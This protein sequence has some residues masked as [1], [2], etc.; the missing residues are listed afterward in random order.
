MKVLFFTK[1]LAGKKID[2]IGHLC[3]K[4]GFDGLDLAVRPDQCVNAENVLTE[5]PKAVKLISDMHLDIPMVT[6]AVDSVN[7]EDKDIKNIFLSCG[8]SGIKFI[9]IGYWLWSPHQRYWKMVDKIRKLLVRFENMSKN[10]NLCTLLHIHSDNCYGCNA[11][12]IMDL[13]R[14]FNP[15]YI[16]VYLDPAHLAFDGENLPMALDIVRGYL[17]MVGVKN[18]GYKHTQ[19]SGRIKWNK[20]LP[21]LAEGI[22]NWEE[23]LR[24][25]LK[26]GYK[27]PLSYHGEIDGYMSSNKIMQGAAIDLAYLRSVLEKTIKNKISDNPIKRSQ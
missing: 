3:E 19:R 20:T 27:G 13:V 15:K 5:L 1:F 24:Q 21:L 4:V 17:R 12:G 16:G 14:G 25:I 6:L 2:E 11:A 22:V 7:P 23:A 9:K 10:H 8:E 26:A 18:A